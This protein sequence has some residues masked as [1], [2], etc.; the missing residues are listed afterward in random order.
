MSFAIGAAVPWT[1]P[2]DWAKGTTERLVWQTDV[3]TGS[4]GHPS[5]RRLRLHP[6]RGFN[7]DVMC[8]PDERRLIDQQYFDMGVRTWALP[9][10]PD[11]QLVNDIA[12]GATEIECATAGYDFTAGGRALLWRGARVWELVSIDAVSAEGITLQE[13]VQ[14]A[15]DGRAR[16]YPVRDAVL[17]SSPAWRELSGDV[18]VLRADMEIEEACDW[19]AAAPATL[20]R[21]LP[22]LEW[23]RDESEDPGS[24]YSRPVYIEDGD[25]SGLTSRVDLAEMSFRMQDHRWKLHGR[26]EQATL[27]SLLY[28]LSG[29]YRTLWVPSFMRDLDLAAPIGDAD[30]AL[31]VAWCGYT[32]FGRQ[33]RNRRDIR[34]ELNDGTSFQRRIVDSIEAGE[35]EMLA[36][37]EPLGEAVSPGAV[38]RI[39]FLSAAQ[40]ASD[41]IEIEHANIADR[42]AQCGVRWESI[43]HDD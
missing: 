43:R 33:Q 35:A 38:R 2:M 25:E 21:G 37:D 16:L 19:P 7:F 4:L 12:N 14:S 8:Y 1:V 29:R 10:W 31:S 24:D 18:A 22:V 9:I 36:I 30:D 17:R 15:W 6:R 5:K 34:I 13:G 11:M 3:A 23:S 27:R 39:S 20:Y 41:A 40:L 28:W 26:Q 32:V 42:D